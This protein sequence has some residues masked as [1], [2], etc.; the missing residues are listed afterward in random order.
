MQILK[1]AYRKYALI[2][3]SINNTLINA[4]LTR[5]FRNC[6]DRKIKFPRDLQIFL[7]LSREIKFRENFFP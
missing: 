1:S 7:S 5:N 6:L 3:V 4:P 2:N